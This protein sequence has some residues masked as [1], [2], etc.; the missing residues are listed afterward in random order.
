M[1]VYHGYTYGYIRPLIRI[2]QFYAY[3]EAYLS[4]TYVLLTI[5]F[6]NVYSFPTYLCIV[7]VF[8][9]LILWC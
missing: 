4:V 9:F 3:W 5:L 7:F 8:D 2:V 6:S 1:L